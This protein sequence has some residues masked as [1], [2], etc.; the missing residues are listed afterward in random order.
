MCKN[1]NDKK[2][3]AVII[4]QKIAEFIRK[5]YMII[6]VL[7]G[8]IVITGAGKHLITRYRTW[9]TV[10]NYKNNEASPDLVDYNFMSMTIHQALRHG[11]FK[12]GEDEKQ[13]MEVVNNLNSMGEFLLLTQAYYKNYKKDLREELRENF[14]DRRYS[15]LK[16]K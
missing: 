14:G 4:I 12:W 7:V 16:Y 9:K 13:I 1:V 3:K 11:L 15:Q 2:M 10:R 6:L 8:L 5:N